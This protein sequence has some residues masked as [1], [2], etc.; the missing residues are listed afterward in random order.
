MKEGKGIYRVGL[1]GFMGLVSPPFF[2]ES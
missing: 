1:K 2:R